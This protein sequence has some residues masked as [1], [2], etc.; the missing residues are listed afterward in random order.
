MSPG[1]VLTDARK[2]KNPRSCNHPLHSFKLILIFLIHYTF[3]LD[4]YLLE[5]NK[6][7]Q[8][9]ASNPLK[10]NPAN[11]RLTL[12]LC[13]LY[14]SPGDEFDLIFYAGTRRRHVP[15]KILVL[16]VHC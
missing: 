3:D 11:Y 6:S 7:G 10:L 2:P 14:M 16:A 13:C 12:S 8:T 1:Q 5:R 15:K 4:L 9:R